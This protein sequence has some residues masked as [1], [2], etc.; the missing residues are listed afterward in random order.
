MSKKTPWADKKTITPRS[1]EI[2]TNQERKREN[3][4]EPNPQQLQTMTQNL[5]WPKKRPV[6][7]YRATTKNAKAVKSKG[8]PRK[9]KQ[10]KQFSKSCQI[11]TCQAKVKRE[12]D[13]MKKPSKEKLNEAII[14]K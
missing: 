3:Q 5:T 13:T 11:I 8:K 1:Q 9:Q 7:R 14:S 12:E 4:Q 10:R 2:T 6:P